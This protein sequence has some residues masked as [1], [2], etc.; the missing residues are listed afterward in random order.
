MQQPKKSQFPSNKAEPELLL[1]KL[2]DFHS[3]QSTV[4][5]SQLQLNISGVS[6]REKMEADVWL[7]RG[8][9]YIL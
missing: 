6:N 1:G 3:Y 4:S 2:W 7:P 9:V 5:I 8:E